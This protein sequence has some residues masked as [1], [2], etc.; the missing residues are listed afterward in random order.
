M[1]IVC[2]DPQVGRPIDQFGSVNVVQSRLA[3]LTTEARLSCMYL[4]EGGLIGDHPATT[5]Q[6]LLVVQ[7]EGWVRGEARQR[8]PIRPGLAAF[9]EAGE[10]HET[11][12][13]TGMTAIVVEADRLDPMVFMPRASIPQAGPE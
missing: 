10:W 6:L 4:G 5:P 3:H 7:G 2:F 9:W 13:D 11:G 8:V 1:E 12:T